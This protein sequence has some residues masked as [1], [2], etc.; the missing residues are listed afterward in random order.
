MIGCHLC[1]HR[2]GVM[3]SWQYPASLRRFSRSVLARMTD[4]GRLQTPLTILKH[5]QLSR[6]CWVRL[7][8]S[9]NSWGMLSRWIY[10]YSGQSKGVPKSKLPMSKVQ[11]LALVQESMLLFMILTSSSGAVLV[12]TSPGQQIWLPPI[13]IRVQF[14]TDFLDWT[15][16]TTLDYVISLWQSAGMLSQSMMQK[17]LVPWIHWFD[18]LSKWLMP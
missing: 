16:Q 12:P 10:M 3:L 9:T 7:Y 5:T 4:W 1:H 17:V 6:T 18:P 14:G 2:S 15:L 13:V 11:N 8:L